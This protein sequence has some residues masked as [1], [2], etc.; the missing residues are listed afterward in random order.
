MFNFT[1]QKSA[2]TSTWTSIV[3]PGFMST[4]NGAPNPP[5]AQTEYTLLSELGEHPVFLRSSPAMFSN[6]I[7]ADDRNAILA[8]GIPA[9]SPA[10]GKTAI[11]SLTSSK[12]FNMNT[13]FK[14]DSGAWGRTGGDYGVRWLHSDMKDMAFF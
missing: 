2:V 5:D 9:L 8:K 6:T 7:S 13:A 12:N 4:H 3:G 11:P 10:A 14:P 1:Y